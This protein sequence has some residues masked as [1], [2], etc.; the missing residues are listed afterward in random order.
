[1]IKLGSKVKWESSARRC[2]TVKHGT[3]VAVVPPRV[4]VSKILNLVLDAQVR[5]PLLMSKFFGMREHESYIVFVE[6]KAWGAGLLYW[7]RE[8]RLE[9]DDEV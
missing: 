1:M 8:G 7:P 4:D 2:K 3:V 9:M 6:A 5:R